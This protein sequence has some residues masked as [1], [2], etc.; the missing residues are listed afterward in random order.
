LNL[1]TEYKL[2][3][4]HED[5]QTTEQKEIGRKNYRR[6]A[7]QQFMPQQD[8]SE[9]MSLSFRTGCKFSKIDVYEMSS[10]YT[11]GFGLNINKI[12]LDYAFVP[13]GFLGTT[14]EINLTC[15]FGQPVQK[16]D[17][18]NQI[19]KGLDFKQGKKLKPIKF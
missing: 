6:I 17:D 12:S 19:F 4:A 1:G 10:A 2:C 5:S 11:L 3:L 9:G 13:F 14:H 15:K 7:K 18:K 8:V 16:Q